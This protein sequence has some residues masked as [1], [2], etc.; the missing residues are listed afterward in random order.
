MGHLHEHETL[1]DCLASTASNLEEKVDDVHV[2][3]LINGPED[4]VIAEDFHF[5]TKNL[6]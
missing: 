5:V 4:V 1:G 6:H 3:D 2:V